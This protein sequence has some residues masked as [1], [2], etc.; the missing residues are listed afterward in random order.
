MEARIVPPL[1]P[2]GPDTPKPPHSPMDKELSRPALIGIVA[3]IA[4]SFYFMFTY[5]GPFQ[6]LGE[7]QLRW[8]NSYNEKLTL[9][10]TMFALI[11]PAAAIWKIVQ[12]GVKTIGPGGSATVGETAVYRKARNIH[13]PRMLL[14]P[15]VGSIV[16]GLGAFNYWRGMT[17]GPLTAVKAKEL[18]DGKKPASSYLTI[19]GVPVWDEAVT[20]NKSGKDSYFPVVSQDWKGGPVAVYVE[21]NEDDLPHPPGPLEMKTFTGMT[22]VGGLPGPVRVGFEK[23]LFKPA[24]GYRVLAI[25]DEPAKLMN[26]A[27]WPTIVGAGL[28]A[29][30]LLVWGVKRIVSRRSPETDRVGA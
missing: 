28:L 14:L 9:I 18:E 27:K 22:E 11:L 26:F 6:W 23:S 13:L 12:V 3:L 20:F 19:E 2:A 1:P 24:A 30:G 7:L 8:M 5:T 16:L 29:A 17:A 25:H 15:L 4:L 10:L 21:C